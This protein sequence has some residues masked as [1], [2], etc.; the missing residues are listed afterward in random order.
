MPGS[1]F[2]VSQQLFG[3]E[4][5]AIIF[6]LQPRLFLQKTLIPCLIMYWVRMVPF[7]MMLV[8]GVGSTKMLIAFRMLP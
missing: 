4:T 8:G 1:F 7:V 2:V 5:A 6:I 3:Q